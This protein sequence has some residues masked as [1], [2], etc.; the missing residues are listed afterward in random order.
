MYNDL[1]GDLLRLNQS[2]EE[3]TCIIGYLNAH[4][5]QQ[6]EFIEFD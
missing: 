5:C 2:D 6:N 4:T 1:D 3:Y